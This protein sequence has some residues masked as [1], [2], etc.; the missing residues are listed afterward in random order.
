MSGQYILN[1]FFLSSTR[2]DSLS[3]VAGITKRSLSA[4]TGHRL[5]PIQEAV[6][7][8]DRQDLTICSDSITPVFLRSALKL[9][10]TNKDK[11][12]EKCLITMYRNRNGHNEKTCRSKRIFMRCSV[13]T[14]QTHAKSVEGRKQGYYFQRE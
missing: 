7:N 3:G 2:D 4:L 14:N 11:K 5:I 9:R 12:P 6:H 8:I 1:H 13:K 10:G